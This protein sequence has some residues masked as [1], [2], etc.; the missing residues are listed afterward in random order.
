MFSDSDDQLTGIEKKMLDALDA[1]YDQWLAADSPL[2]LSLVQ[3]MDKTHK[4]ILARLSK[5]GGF[6]MAEMMKNPEAALLQ[7]DR[8]RELLIRAMSQQES[9]G[10]QVLHFPT[11]DET[12]PS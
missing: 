11:R 7:L 9:V 6:N 8:M 5:R 3:L 2:P 10:A 4:T 1:A 12:P